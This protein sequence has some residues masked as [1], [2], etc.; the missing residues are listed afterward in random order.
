MKASIAGRLRNTV[1]P[2]SKHLLPVFEEV[3]NA[4]QAIEATDPTPPFVGAALCR[5]LMVRA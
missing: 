4:F 2:K 3:M 1:L 5:H